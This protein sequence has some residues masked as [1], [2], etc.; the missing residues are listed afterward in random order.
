MSQCGFHAEGE[1]GKGKEKKKSRRRGTEGRIQT[2]KEEE[3]IEI[4]RMDGMILELIR[5]RWSPSPIIG[6]PTS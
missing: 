2:Q 3:E 5:S 4:K 6:G 1:R